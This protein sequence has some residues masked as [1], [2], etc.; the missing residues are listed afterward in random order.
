MNKNAEKLVKALR[1]G[2][3]TQT[4]YKLKGDTSFCCLGVACDIYSKD[5][6]KANWDNRHFLGVTDIM[7]DE[8]AEWFGFY[9]RNGLY[10]KGSLVKL[11]DG[12]ESFE[13]IASLIESEPEG[14]FKKS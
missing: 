10:E 13:T 7:P 12:G 14:L 1:S 2:K 3:Y 11:N 5:T 4:M 8:V 9:S 6:G